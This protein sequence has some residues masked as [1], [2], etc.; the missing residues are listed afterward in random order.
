MGSC[1]I[2]S[3][4]TSVFLNSLGENRLKEVK[5][6]I[7]GHSRSLSKLGSQGSNLRPLT[8]RS[9]LF[10]QT[11]GASLAHSS[12]GRPEAPLRWVS[13]TLGTVLADWHPSFPFRFT[14]SSSFH[15]WGK[16]KLRDG[17]WTSAP[18]E[19]C[20]KLHQATTTTTQWRS[21]KEK[22]GE[23]VKVTYGNKESSGSDEQEANRPR[24]EMAFP[25]TADPYLFS[26][27]GASAYPEH[28]CGP[29][30]SEQTPQRER[31]TTEAMAILRGWF[32][33]WETIKARLVF[34]LGHWLS[35]GEA[36]KRA[37]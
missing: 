23:A 5:Q 3:R 11:H 12:G 28:E 1:F 31:E 32:D 19:G 26:S 10:T 15:K 16:Q 36:D 8:A 4:L 29:D 34:P 24:G 30:L 33:G 35:S 7:Q 25:R 14:L 13:H 18:G 27:L 20:I 6:L 37:Q 17:T 9:V 2:L 21:I 22:T